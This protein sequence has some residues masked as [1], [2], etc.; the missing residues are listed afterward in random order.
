[1]VFVNIPF[2][3]AFLSCHSFPSSFSTTYSYC[4]FPSSSSIFISPRLFYFMAPFSSPSS[5]QP[6]FFFSFSISLSFSS[7]VIFSCFFL[8]HLF[9]FSFFLTSPFL[10]LHFK[11]YH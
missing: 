7:F 6:L 11:Y 9:I 5:L 3:S 10:I 4:C 1:V 8:L 2:N